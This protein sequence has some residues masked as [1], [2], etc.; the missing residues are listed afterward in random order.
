[1]KA[2]WKVLLLGVV[3]FQWVQALVFWHLLDVVRL[4]AEGS[5]LHDT[6]WG[7]DTMR[8]VW[9][10]GAMVTAAAVV[11]LVL[12]ARAYIGPSPRRP[13]ARAAEAVSRTRGTD[14]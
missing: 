5:W 6:A 3:L 9:V 10:T 2:G 4:Q 7:P 11:A 1:M 14:A 8:W 12:E 13:A